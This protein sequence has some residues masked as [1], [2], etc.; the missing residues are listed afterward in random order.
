MEGIV[1]KSRYSIEKIEQ[2]YFYISTNLVDSPNIKSRYKTSLIINE[3][4]TQ[5]AEW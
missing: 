5:N 1:C 2:K 4:G 3:R